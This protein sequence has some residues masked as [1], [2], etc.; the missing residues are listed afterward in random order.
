[1][2]PRLRGNSFQGSTVNIL[3]IS[4]RIDS[5]L[6]VWPGD[7]PFQRRVSMSL[8]TGDHL[9]LSSIHS[10]VHLGAHADAPNHYQK[11][12]AGIGE[13]SLHYYYGPCQVMDLTGGEAPAQRR[14]TP[15]H[16]NQSV[17][18]PRVLLKTDSFPDPKHYNT[19]FW[20]LSPQLVE[21]FHQAEVILVGLDTPSVDPFEDQE[22]RSHQAIA[23]ADM[24][25]LEGLCLQSVPAGLYTLCAFPLKLAGADAS[26]VR[27][28][29]L[30]QD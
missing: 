8:E 17:A 27:A 26:P 24:A 15:D 10:T 12:G 5:E 21:F 22:L 20:A 29:L 7:V 19:D 4:P 30:Q 2:D 18:A 13:R 1:M 9:G 16:L 3:D 6:A 28:V 23:A 14:L 11:G 25:I